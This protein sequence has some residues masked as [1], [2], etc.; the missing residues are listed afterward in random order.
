MRVAFGFLC[1]DADLAVVPDF[2]LIPGTNPV[3]A[4]PIRRKD[5]GERFSISKRL[6]DPLIHGKGSRHGD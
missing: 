5:N 2:D 6:G 4:N 3:P 1:S